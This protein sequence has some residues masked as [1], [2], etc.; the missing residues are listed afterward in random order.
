MASV[1]QVTLQG[2]VK[3]ALPNAIFEVEIPNGQ[4]VI[5]YLSGRMRKNKINILVGDLC[6]MELSPYDLSKGRIIYRRK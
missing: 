4:T 1:D 6:D 5:A 3:K 2:I